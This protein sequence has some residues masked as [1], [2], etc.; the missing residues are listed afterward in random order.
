M[1]EIRKAVD[2][3]YERGVRVFL[4]EEASEIEK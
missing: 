4:E 1:E 3:E 2:N